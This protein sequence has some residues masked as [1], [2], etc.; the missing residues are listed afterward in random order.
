MRKELDSRKI[1]RKVQQM[2]AKL[3]EKNLGGKQNE[4]KMSE[5]VD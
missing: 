1:I 5:E 4:E 3:T 2:R